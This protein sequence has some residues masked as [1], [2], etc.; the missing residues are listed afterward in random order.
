MD[1]VYQPP[2]AN[3]QPDREPSS[4][5]GHFDFGR[6][7]QLAGSAYGQQVG[8]GVGATLLL[9]FISLAMAITII[10]I[11]FGLPVLLAGIPVF[12][13]MMIRREASIG[14]L[15]S[16]FRSYGWVLL[17]F[18]LV[19]V[20]SYIIML[21][22]SLPQMLYLYGDFP[23]GAIGSDSFGEQMQVWAEVLK[24]KQANP[25]DPDY[26]WRVLISYAAYPITMYIG[27][28]LILIYPLIIIRKMTAIDAIKTSWAVT[29]PYQ[30]WLVLLQF[31]SGIIAVSG[32]FLCFIGL[33]FSM[34][35]SMSLHGAAIYQ[36]FGEDKEGPAPQ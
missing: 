19:T 9:P 22:F 24:E 30:W 33:L 18:F 25:F 36:L 10:G 35:F 4:G 8:L 7:F 15:F 31:V 6:T 3:L 11:P 23:F 26:L 20:A 28:R 27:A 1:N 14:D 32:M 5:F 29:A 13:Y 21:P 2:Q 34:P 17:A 16:G 12:G